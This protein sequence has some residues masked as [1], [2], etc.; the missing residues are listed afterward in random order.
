MEKSKTLIIAEMA[1]AHDGSFNKAISI[2][3][4]AHVSGADAIGIH[5]TNIPEY[6]VPHYGSGKGRVSSGKEHLKI[7][8]YLNDINLTKENWI[9]FSKVAKSIGIDICVMPNDNDSLEFCEKHLNPNYYVVPASAF[10]EVDLI[11][12]VAKTNR[13]T[14]FRTGGATLGE[15][16][17]TINLFRVHGGGEITLLHGFQNYPT[18]LE[19]TNIRQIQ[20]LAKIFGVP[21]GLADHIDGGDTLA[22]SIPLMALALGA[23][24][25]EKHIT[26]DRKEKGEDFESALNP[27]DFKEFVYLIRSGEIAL[28]QINYSELSPAAEHYREISRK[29]MV[30]AR[31]IPANTKITRED[32]TFKRADIGLSPTEINYVIGRVQKV[33]ILKNE[34]ITLDQLI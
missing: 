15:I 9:E 2:L 14:L 25:I 22:K 7:Y 16:E 11:T 24:C 13:P 31:A 17:S 18:K 3:N 4:A 8:E 10:I 5:V 30:A 27:I 1:W 12:A 6:L 21:V 34:S 33:S 19:D 20:S 29:R 26:Y 32:I 28:G 23:T